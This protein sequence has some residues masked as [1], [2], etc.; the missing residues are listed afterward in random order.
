[1]KVSIMIAL[2]AIS[3]GACLNDD[4]QTFK[5]LYALEG[6]WKMVTK[7][8]AICEEWKLINA[9]YLQNRGYR[10][11]GN[12]TVINERVSLTNTKDGIFYTST[13][14][15]QNNQKPIAFK[16]SSATGNSFIFENQDHDYPKR[17]VYHLITSDSLYAF[18]DDGSDDPKKRQNFRYKKQ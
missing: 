7:R 12:D 5:R 14:E 4:S 15:D 18:I 13:V 17:I 6:T 1:M 9:D 10:V 2:F 11:S 16:L 8:G 3:S